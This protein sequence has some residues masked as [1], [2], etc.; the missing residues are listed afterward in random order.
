M[1]RHTSFGRAMDLWSSLTKD[2]YVLQIVREGLSWSWF[3]K[4]PLLP[5]ST[6]RALRH[7]DSALRLP[8]PLA[9]SLLRE[10]EQLLSDGVIET[11]SARGWIHR[12]FPVFRT[13]QSQ[14]RWVIDCRTLNNCLVSPHFKMEG[15]KTLRLLAFKGD[16][17]ASV[18]VKSAFNQVNIAP[19]SR[20]LLQFVVRG[21]LYQYKRMPFGPSPAPY[22]WTKLLHPVIVKLRSLGHRVSSYAD[23][24][25]VLGRTKAECAAALTALRSLLTELGIPIN[26]AKSSQ[27]PSQSIE[28]LGLQWN[29]KT[30]RIS[31]PREKIR[32]ICKEIRTL[33]A[34][35]TASF[36]RIA[37]IVGKLTFCSQV[38]PLLKFRISMIRTLLRTVTNW[39]H[40]VLISPL[41]LEALRWLSLPANLHRLNGEPFTP[42]LPAS[43]VTLT[44]DA[45]PSGWGASLQVGPK[46][47]TTQGTWSP[48][49]TLLSS[50]AKE[51][52]ALVLAYFS[53][54]HL[55]PRRQPIHFRT[56][57]MTAL[58]YLSR[59]G[60]RLPALRLILEPLARAL[61]KEKRSFR[62]SHIP[63][64]LNGVADRL[65]R[66]KAR[67]HDWT[68]S[69]EIFTQLSNR[70]GTHSV[71]LFASRLN[72]HCQRFVA[73][74]P[75]PLAS[76][77]NGCAYD[78]QNHNAWAAPPFPL[79][80]KFLNKLVKTPSP[81][82]L[83]LPHWPSAPW[84]PLLNLLPVWE[85]L[86][87]PP[88][89]VRWS[90]R[91]LLSLGQPPSMLALRCLPPSPSLS[92]QQ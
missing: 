75:D 61:V 90:P 74:R 6:R 91:D 33:T 87:L 8:P 38:M 28:H 26:E 55:F 79:L 1:P 82:T 72:S 41:A 2:P 10:I 16:W 25:I 62:V 60:G 19:Q 12:I 37:S 88:Q 39:D 40:H 70:W 36:R 46:F 59:L 68:T 84:F 53:L 43:E 13:P 58:S 31:V 4:A 29:L 22:L 78:A 77:L 14:P 76:A 83:I 15:V 51:L 20:H 63:G 34:S 89:A 24:L 44:T 7:W 71:D 66:S 56:D 11:C 32:L 5:R 49:E 69:S 50:N 57:N 17:A 67:D 73:W 85:I 47:C 35:P 65:S 81:T 23:D 80:Q 30:G 9:S 42:P 27:E 3:A 48:Q 92:A 54:R 45:S 52:L 18:D 64:T 21:K 86:P